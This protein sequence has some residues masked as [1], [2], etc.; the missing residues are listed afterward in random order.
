[1]LNILTASIL[2]IFLCEQASVE[3]SLA[4]T[5]PIAATWEA[6]TSHLIT[7]MDNNDSAPMPSSINLQLLNGPAI[8]LKLVSVIAENITSSTGRYN[9][10]IPANIAA[11]Q[12]ALG[13][14]GGSG[15]SFSPFFN[16]TTSSG[17]SASVSPSL[18]LQ[19]ND[20]GQ[21]HHFSHSKQSPAHPNNHS[22]NDQAR[23]HT[24][25]KRG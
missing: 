5:A 4:F 14:N 22:P 12:Y 7:W 23:Q 25:R 1:M 8:N 24:D 13:A 2:A 10:A 19:V 21:W 11:G 6:G 18:A 17:S 20:R 3:A 15:T 16:I 9:W